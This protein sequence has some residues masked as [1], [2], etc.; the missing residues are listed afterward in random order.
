M[1]QSTVWTYLIVLPLPLLNQ[2]ILSTVK[3]S[4]DILFCRMLLKLS[5]PYIHKWTTLPMR[6]HNR[7]RID[8]IINLGCNPYI[9]MS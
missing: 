6:L 5:K 2:Y 9:R 3:L 8:M 4:I 7:F 1:I